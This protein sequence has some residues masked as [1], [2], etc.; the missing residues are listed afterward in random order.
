MK[1][2]VSRCPS[3]GKISSRPWVFAR[4]VA[5]L[6]AVLPDGFA[7][8]LTRHVTRA[9]SC[10]KEREGTAELEE[11]SA[12]LLP[13]MGLGWRPSDGQSLKKKDR[14]RAGPMARL[15]TPVAV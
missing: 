10:L 5:L 9:A 11:C 13:L 3:D 15:I 2:W 7:R 1:V 12:M 4:A 8:L 14:K 6:P